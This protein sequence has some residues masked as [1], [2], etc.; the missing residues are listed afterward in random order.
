VPEEA[1]DELVDHLSAFL[2]AELAVA[3]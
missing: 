2:R 3:E 1:P